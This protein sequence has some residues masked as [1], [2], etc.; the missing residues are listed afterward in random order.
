MLIVDIN[1]WGACAVAEK[2]GLPWAVFCPYPLPAPSKDAP[3]FGPGLAPARGLPGRLRDALVRPLITG[4]LERKMLPGL[5]HVRTD[6][7]LPALTHLGEQFQRPPLLLYLT[8]EPFEYPRSDWL[9]NLVMVGPCEWE[10]LPGEGFDLTLNDQ[11]LVVVTTSSEFQDDAVLVQAV[12]DGLSNDRVQVVATV[13]AGDARALRVPP[14]ARVESFVPHS[15]LFDR[16]SVVVTHAGMGAT[17]K[18]LA[19]GVPVC[20]V[21]FGRDQAEV[22]RRVEVAGAGVRL[23]RRRLS[24]KNVR[25]A[26][27]EA[28]D[29]QHGAGRI[30]EAYR[31][32]GGSTAAADAVEVLLPKGPKAPAVIQHSVQ[33]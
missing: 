12:L 32:A 1:S 16:A 8:C 9:P 4:T 27:F 2:S 23:P 7:G 21:P 31:R 3:P 33:H 24:A 15:L 29:K 25:A 28:M 6:L 20:A 26:V 14:N 30:A 19:R 13:P 10:P 5:N 17:Q 22:A 11:P 18:A